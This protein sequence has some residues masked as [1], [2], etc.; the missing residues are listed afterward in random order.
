M[1]TDRIKELEDKLAD[2]KVRWPA[3]SVPPSMW[4]QLEVLEDELEEAKKEAQI[5]D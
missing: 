2:L 5:K 1:A 3:Q 4:Q